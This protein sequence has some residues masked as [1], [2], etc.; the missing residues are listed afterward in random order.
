MADQC[1]VDDSGN[2]RDASDIT[3]YNS[4]SDEQ[5]L[6][7]AAAGIVFLSEFSLNRGSS[8]LQINPSSVA[9]LVRGRLAG[10]RGLLRQSM[11]T[12][13]GKLLFLAFPVL[14]HPTL[15]GSSSLQSRAVSRRTMISSSQTSWMPPTR[16]TRAKTRER[17]TTPRILTTMRQV[18]ISSLKYPTYIFEKIA[19]LLSSKT[20]PA[21]AGAASTKPQTRQKSTTTKRKH[22]TESASARAPK[23][24]RV[25]VEDVEDEGDAPKT[26]T[27]CFLT[28]HASLSLNSILQV[29]NPIHLFYDVVPTNAANSTGKP[30]DR[31]YKCRHG[32]RKIITITK[33]MRHNVGSMASLQLRSYY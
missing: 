29:K 21:R 9:A 22:S 14:A 5:A 26:T 19:D 6:P 31:H 12:T 16:R 4:E 27:V 11:R 18:I 25:T 7:T 15:L 20:V 24:G 10:S 28:L 32:N 23:V 17:T 30:G 13:M 3:F 33:A 1:A 2:L 8:K